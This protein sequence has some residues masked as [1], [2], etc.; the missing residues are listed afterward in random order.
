MT[1]V[2]LALLLVQFML[3]GCK[4]TETAVTT[5]SLTEQEAARHQDEMIK[6]SL[7]DSK[8]MVAAKVNGEPITMFFVLRE[9]N[10]IVPQYLKQG[11][12]RTPEIDKKVRADAL[13]DLIFETLAV[14]E[15]R[16]RGMTVKPEAIDA[17]IRNDG[18]DQSLKKYL[19][20][21]G[22]ADADFRKGIEQDLLFEMIAGQE[23]DAKIKVTEAALRERYRKEKAQ[24]KTADA[25][26]KQMTFEQAR[27]LI[28]QK[29][30]EEEGEKRMRQ[31]EM[32]LRKNATIEIADTKQKHG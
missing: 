17:E 31:W 14:Q 30:R 3:A 32:D 25:A 10:A 20:D 13:N 6:Q 24:W 1:A 15:A 12:Q 29:V 9:M 18:S 11:Q 23:I 7:E 5:A 21:S 4:K 8:K 26:H 19:A 2:V 22:L 27:A 16:K 28:E